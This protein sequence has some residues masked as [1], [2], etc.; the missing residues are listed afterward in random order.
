MPGSRRLGVGLP[1]L[2]QASAVQA[3]LRE[4]ALGDAAL[5]GLGQA[6]DAQFG[7]WNLTDAEREVAL[8]LLK[9]LSTKEIAAVRAGPV[10]IAQDKKA[11]AKS[12]KPAEA[13]APATPRRKSG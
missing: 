12:E 1:R 8:L 11:E 4:A 5:E 10:A 13:E 2:A 3:R 6:I 7:R 9:G